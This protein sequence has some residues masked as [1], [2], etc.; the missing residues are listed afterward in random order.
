MDEQRQARL[1]EILNQFEALEGVKLVESDDFDSTSINVFITLKA[2]SYVGR[3]RP[4]VFSSGIR[5]IKATVQRICKQSGIEMVHM[6]WP[7]MQYESMNGQKYKNGYDHD[8][9]KIS[10]YI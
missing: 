10:L 1:T 4:M 2:T 5:N 8:H 3:G 9:L 7:R 6:D